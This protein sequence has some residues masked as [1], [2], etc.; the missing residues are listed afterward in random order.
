MWLKNEAQTSHQ[1]DGSSVPLRSSDIVALIVA[2]KTH[3]KSKAFAVC[4]SS[5]VGRIV[6]VF[7][8]KVE[9]R[10]DLEERHCEKEKPKHYQS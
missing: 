6:C 8:R 2:P 5:L 3:K 1:R 9:N 7:H 10:Y 4:W